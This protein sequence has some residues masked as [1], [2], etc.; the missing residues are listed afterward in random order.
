MSDDEIMDL[1]QKINMKELE[2]YRKAVGKRTRHQV[3]HLND[4]LKLKKKCCKLI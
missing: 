1:S 4:S 2:E 3:V